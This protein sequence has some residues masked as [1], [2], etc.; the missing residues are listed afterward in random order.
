MEHVKEFYFGQA[1]NWTDGSH[2]AEDL[3]QWH[4]YLLKTFSSHFNLEKNCKE[5]NNVIPAEGICVRR[6]GQLT[7]YD[8]YKLKSKLFILGESNATEAEPES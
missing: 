4:D 8:A 3:I 2:V 7:N 6:D 5:C 1:K